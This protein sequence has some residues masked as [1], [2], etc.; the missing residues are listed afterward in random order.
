MTD[1]LNGNECISLPMVSKVFTVEE[2][3]DHLRV[4]PRA[5]REWIRKGH[6]KATK[7][8]RLVRVKEEDLQ[9]FIDQG[10]Q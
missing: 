6:L 2:V 5:V 4:T 9:A 1:Q 3:A 10:M 7:I 8:G